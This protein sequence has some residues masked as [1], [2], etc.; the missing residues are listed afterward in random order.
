ML[1]KLLWTSLMLLILGAPAAAQAEGPVT[2]TSS[3]D[4]NIST[5]Y[6]WARGYVNWSGISWAETQVTI[7]DTPQLP[8]NSWLRIAYKTY[9]GGAWHQH[10]LQPDPILK[11]GNGG[12]DTYYKYFNGPVKDVWWDL[13]SK[14]N[15]TTYCTGWK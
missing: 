10:Y 4:L 5:N 8:S 14:R 3:R 6:A 11:V 13:C 15:G 12:S 7:H 2:I 1:R 9:S